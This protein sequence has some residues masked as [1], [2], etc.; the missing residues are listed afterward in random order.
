MLTRPTP[1][2][3]RRRATTPPERVH[4]HTF[5]VIRPD[6]SRG[7]RKDTVIVLPRKNVDVIVVADNPGF[8]MIHCHNTYHQEVGMMTTLDYLI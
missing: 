5:Q 4:G 8:W 2:N 1:R 3:H 7:P 6:G